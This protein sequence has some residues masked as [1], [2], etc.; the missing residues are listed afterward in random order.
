MIEDKPINN[1][2]RKSFKENPKNPNRVEDFRKFLAQYKGRDEY[3]VTSTLT[4]ILS[5]MMIFCHY[6][7]DEEGVPLPFS[8]LVRIAEAHYEAAIGVDDLEAGMLL[9]EGYCYWYAVTE[10]LVLADAKAKSNT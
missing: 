2:P 6:E 1:P 4:D 10:Q 3:D 8:E 5:D 7:K 9:D